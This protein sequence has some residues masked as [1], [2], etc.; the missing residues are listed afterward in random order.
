MKL[1]KSTCLDKRGIR[2][3]V[4]FWIISCVFC[5]FIHH[6]NK[7]IFQNNLKN[8]SFKYLKRN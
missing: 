3:C 5:V 6:D 7:K 8:F 1:T 2:M 4:D